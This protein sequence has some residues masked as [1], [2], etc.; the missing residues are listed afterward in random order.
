MTTPGSD[1]SEYHEAMT[2]EAVALASSIVKAMYKDPDGPKV[3]M[4]LESIIADLARE[5]PEGPPEAIIEALGRRGAHVTVMVEV[6]ARMVVTVIEA[7]AREGIAVHLD[8][9]A[10]P[11]DA[12]E[13]LEDPFPEND[14]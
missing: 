7:A 1:G 10:G 14:E 5:L 13:D 3:R 2:T 8:A 12:L 9:L 11:F 6:M 4:L